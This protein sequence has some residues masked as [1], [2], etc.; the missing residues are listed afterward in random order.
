MTPKEEAISRFQAAK[1]SLWNNEVR[2]TEEQKEAAIL[3]A[4]LRSATA[5]MSGCETAMEKDRKEINF[6]KEVLKSMG[7]S[8]ED[9]MW[10]L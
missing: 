6:M 4:K 9:I 5:R 10:N 2:F 3:S 7:V 1:E 8:D